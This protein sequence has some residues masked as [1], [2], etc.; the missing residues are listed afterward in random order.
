MK[1][2]IIIPCYNEERTISKLLDKVLKADIGKVKKE[3]IIID[4]GSR[5]KTLS[6]AEKYVKNKSYIK[7]LKNKNNRGKGFSIRK[8]LKKATGDIIL[9]QDA[10]LEY[11]PSDYN[12]LIKPI[13]NNEVKVVYGS[14]WLR[15]EESDKKYYLS[16]YGTRILT[17]LANTL[18]NAE[19]TDESTC[20]KIFSKEVL[21][22]IELEC[23]GFEFCPEITAKI[24]KKGYKI[25][26]FPIK[27][28][29]RSF[30]EGK[31]INWK[32]GFQAVWTLIKYR[33]KE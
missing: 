3:I 17:F 14:R 1:L 10:D 23:E 2:S 5:D 8:G 6:I 32:D 11:Y 33:F 20:Y 16:W 12:E 27:Y 21:D 24:K 22:N 19:I 30:E 4:D 29:P 25:K 9:I 15:K 31:K 13:I 28:N 7:L 18:Y 26:E